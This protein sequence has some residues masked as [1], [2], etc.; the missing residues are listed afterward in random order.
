MA[1]RDYAVLAPGCKISLWLPRDHPYITGCSL[2]E[3][4]NI[5]PIKPKYSKTVT[6]LIHLQSIPLCIKLFWINQ[7]LKTVQWNGLS[8]YYQWNF[9]VTTLLYFAYLAKYCVGLIK[10]YLYTGCLINWLTP[11]FHHLNIQD[12][13]TRATL[14]F[15]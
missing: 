11:N 14:H 7:K 6:L 13:N 8:T 15:T 4:L 5:L 12:Q 2:S 10:N 3:Q 1:F 9:T